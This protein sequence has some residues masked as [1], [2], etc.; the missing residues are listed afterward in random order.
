MITT[1][2]ALND[3]NTSQSYEDLDNNRYAID[4]KR[5]YESRRKF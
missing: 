5:E 3:E 2:P 1:T 4:N